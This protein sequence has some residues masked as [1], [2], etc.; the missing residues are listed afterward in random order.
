MLL[1][2][3]KCRTYKGYDFYFFNELKEDNKQQEDNITSSDYCICAINRGKPSNMFFA[4]GC[5]HF[6]YFLEKDFNVIFNCP[7]SYVQNIILTYDIFT[8]KL[9]SCDTGSDRQ[10]I[11]AIKEIAVLTNELEKLDKETV[12]IT[13]SYTKTDE[14]D[15]QP[16]K[17][18]KVS[19]K[20]QK[21]TWYCDR[22]EDDGMRFCCDASN[23][24]NN[25]QSR[26]NAYSRTSFCSRCEDD[27]MRI[28]DNF[29]CLNY[30]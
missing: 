4:R 26:A 24:G 23:C 10:T 27:S 7:G 25:P 8:I 30:Q 20:K 17:K 13:Q 3:K 16:V 14:C 15:G 12:Q 18:Q 9:Y 2:L 22:C 28:C 1:D 19:A 29:A 11:Y 6:N 5:N 21:V